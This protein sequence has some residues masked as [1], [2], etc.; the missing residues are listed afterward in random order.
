M[1]SFIYSNSYHIKEWLVLAPTVGT[2]T[3]IVQMCVQSRVGYLPR[4]AS[5]IGHKFNFKK[6]ELI[7]RPAF[8]LI[9]QALKN[10]EYIAI[11]MYI[12]LFVY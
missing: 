2:F 3:L 1:S 8:A 5:T 12:D 11:V 10:T 4:E 6:T 9:S 7:L